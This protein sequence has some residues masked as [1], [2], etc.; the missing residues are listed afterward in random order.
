MVGNC[1]NLFFKLYQLQLFETIT[2]WKTAVTN[3]SKCIE[4][5]LNKPGK[6]VFNFW[7]PINM[8]NVKPILSI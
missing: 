3:A 2:W 1:H 4:K 7:N 5:L 8:V 6:A